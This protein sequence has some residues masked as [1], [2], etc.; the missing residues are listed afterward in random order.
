MLAYDQA[1]IPLMTK[2]QA[3]LAGVVAPESHGPPSLPSKHVL[4]AEDALWTRSA[5]HVP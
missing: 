5:E 1:S 3:I 2:P 4:E